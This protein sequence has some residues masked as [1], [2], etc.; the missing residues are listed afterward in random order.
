MDSRS[1]ALFNAISADLRLTCSSVPASAWFDSDV[2]IEFWPGITNRQ[3]AAVSLRNS[4]IKKYEGLNSEA[5]SAA[6]ESFIADNNRCRD[7]VVTQGDFTLDDVVDGEL[8]Q[9]F[10]KQFAGS[11]ERFSPRVFQRVFGVGNGKSAGV[12]DT[13]FYSKFFSSVFTTCKSSLYRLYACYLTSPSWLAAENIRRHVYD[14]FKVV[15]GSTLSTVAKT[16]K[17]AR[18]ICTEPSLEM[19]F[20]KALSSVFADVLL[21]YHNIDMSFQPERNKDLARDASLENGNATIDLTSASN[22]ISLKFL[23]SKLPNELLGWLKL[24]RTEHT[25]MPDGTVVE[26]HMLSTMGNGYTSTFQTLLFANTLRACYRALN[27]SA[28]V[29]VFGDDIICSRKAVPLFLRTLARYGFIVSAKSFTDGDFR[30]SCGGD[31]I[32]GVDIRGV[33]CKTLHTMQDKYSLFN[34]LLRW[35]AKHEINLFRT[36]GL[37]QKGTKR[38]FVPNFEADTAGYHVPLV[39]AMP[40]CKPLKAA[41]VITRPLTLCKGFATKILL[42]ESYSVMYYYSA[43][44]PRQPVLAVSEFEKYYGLHNSVGIFVA[45]VGGYLRNGERSSLEDAR[46]TISLCSSPGW[47]DCKVG[48]RLLGENGWRRWKALAVALF[49]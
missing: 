38:T 13:D 40:V 4:I 34:R 31:F 29:D 26:L 42:N 33:Y 41:K 49:V 25:I 47:E 43:Y 5:I 37:L 17:I 44:R 1:L 10:Y 11:S 27:I 39:V 12:Y 36:L 21:E 23:E 46:L 45:G 30:E 16:T 14:E 2:N 32:N 7:F 28:S 6:I 22:S 3:A 8:E 35:S 9:L 18:T 19:F 15:K 24:T 48:T 20:Q